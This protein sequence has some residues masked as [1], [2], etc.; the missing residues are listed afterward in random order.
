M[1]KARLQGLSAGIIL[2]QQ[3]LLAFIMA[4]DHSKTPPLLRRKLKRPSNQR[5][6]IW[7]QWRKRLQKKNP[8][9]VTYTIKVKTNMTATEI[10]DSLSKEK[11]HQ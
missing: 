9:I 2:Q 8:S 7:I 10:A 6:R 3:S 1:N 5:I 11:N 4:P